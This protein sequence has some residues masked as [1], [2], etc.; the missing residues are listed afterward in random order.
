MAALLSGKIGSEQCLTL[1]HI[2][3]H[4]QYHPA[5]IRVAAV[6]ALASLTLIAGCTDQPTASAPNPPTGTPTTQAPDVVRGESEVDMQS[7]K[8]ELTKFPDVIA[9][10]DMDH[11]Y[12]LT[13]EQ[14]DYSIDRLAL[15]LTMAG[16]NPDIIRLGFKYVCP[17]RILHVNQALAKNERTKDEFATICRT[18]PEQRT[19][20]QKLLID[21]AGPGACAS[22]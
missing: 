6:V 22:N 20:D 18:P 14:C 2:Q 12:T 3:A 10:P 7:W 15:Q 19:E 1:G 11:L 9:S 16:A 4:L 5:M 17:Q 21:T 8:D 13:A